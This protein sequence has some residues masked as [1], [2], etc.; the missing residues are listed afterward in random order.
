MP[1]MLQAKGLPKEIADSILGKQKRKRRRTKKESYLQ[2]R[3]V[4]QETSRIR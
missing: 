3:I 1:A 2:E 4:A